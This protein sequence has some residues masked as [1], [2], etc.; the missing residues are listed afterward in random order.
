M[1]K[2]EKE[3]LLTYLDGRIMALCDGIVKHIDA[4]AVGEVYDSAYDLLK[5]MEDAL[6]VDTMLKQK[7]HEA[8]T[9]KRKSP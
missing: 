5:D 7:E 2:N 3:A 1:T 4:D 8:L 9:L 6:S